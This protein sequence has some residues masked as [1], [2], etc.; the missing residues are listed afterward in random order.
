M[1][2][3]MVASRMLPWPPLEHVEAHEDRE[4]DRHADRERAPRA[5]GQRVDDGEA[6]AGE[7]DGRHEQDGDAG[8]G[9]GDGADFGAGDL[10]QRPAAAPGRRPERGEVVHGAGEADA[11][12]EPDEPGRE[13]KLRREHRTDERPRAGDGGEVMAEEHPAAGRVVVVTVV[14]RVRGV[15]RE[16]SSDST[17]AAMNAL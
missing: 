16:S 7:R 5:L 2:P 10:G 13:A 9:A 15:T 1:T 3:T 14:F 4:R 12:D 11:G 17:F 6:E 8:G